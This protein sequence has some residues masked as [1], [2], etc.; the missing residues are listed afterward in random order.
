MKILIAQKL[1][2]EKKSLVVLLK[3]F[4]GCKEDHQRLLLK[5]EFYE[6]LGP[7]FYDRLYKA[8]SKLF[9]GI[10]DWEARMEEIFNDTFLT[11]FEEI[12]TFKIGDDWG[13]SECEKVLLNW[14]SVIA[15]NKFLKLAND[16]K[17]E[18]KALK[19]YKLEQVRENKTGEISERKGY[20]QTYDK[21]KFDIFWNNLNAMSKEVLLI[22]IENGTIKEEISD[23]I[24]DKET[25]LIK[26]KNDL[27]SCA[28]PKEIKKYVSKS[29]FKERNT[30][31][32]PDEALEY[33]KTKYNVTSGAIR[34]A[35]Q[36][37]LEGLRNCKI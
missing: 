9:R 6:G 36:R 15:N 12:E 24:S 1:D 31:H 17:N 2:D 20:R 23:H 29:E 4:I 7:K 18:R 13:D 22:C 34:K 30:D 11:A 28:I 37:A 27:D 5:T 16:S 14:L 19:N 3:S 33:L 26:L 21:A 32:L 25:E 8:A 35:K 10:P